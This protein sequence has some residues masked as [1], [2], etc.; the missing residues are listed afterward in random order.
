VGAELSGVSDDARRAMR[1][2]GLGAWQ[3]IVFETDAATVAMAPVPNDG[4]VLVA[5]RRE[6]PLGFVRRLLARAAERGTRWLE[7]AA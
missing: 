5:A 6:T 4:L 7:E 3:G 1:H 2:L